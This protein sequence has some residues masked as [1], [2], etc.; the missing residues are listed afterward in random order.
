MKDRRKQLLDVAQDIIQRR[1]Y[2]AFS[3][4]DLC[5]IVHIRKPS[6]H[7]HFPKK[8]DIE[9]ALIR[10]YT[11]KFSEIL[12]NIPAQHSSPRAQLEAYCYLFDYTLS[13]SNYEKLCLGGIMGAELLTLPKTIHRAIAEFCRVNEEWLSEIIQAGA[14]K[15][16]FK[17]ETDP[18]NMA[19]LIF[20]SLE[21]AM[22][23]ARVEG[24]TEYVRQVMQQFRNLLYTKPSRATAS[25]QKRS[26]T[27]TAAQRRTKSKNNL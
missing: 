13:S 9:L 21:G 3:Y 19:R 12:H 4:Q 15:A 14:A 23:A 17:P 22:L 24:R 6:I 11:E 16:L 27:G 20:S 7:H 8:E 18:D 26:K 10:R 2:N 1:G 25:R 5:D